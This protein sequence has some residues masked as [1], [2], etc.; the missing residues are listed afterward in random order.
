MP[1]SANIESDSSLRKIS[2]VYVDY[3]LLNLDVTFCMSVEGLTIIGIWG[4][5]W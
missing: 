4:K 3:I 2:A 1:Q 5:T